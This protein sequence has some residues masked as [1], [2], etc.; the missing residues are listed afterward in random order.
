MKLFRGLILL[1]SFLFFSCFSYSQPTLLGVFNSSSSHPRM[2]QYTGGDTTLTVLDSFSFGHGY[3]ISSMVEGPDGKLYSLINGMDSADYGALISYDYVNNHLKVLAKFD[4]QHNGTDPLGKLLLSADGLLY[5]LTNNGGQ[6]AGGIIFSFDINTD[7][8]TR[9]ANF[10]NYDRPQG[11]LVQAQS[12]TFYTMTYGGGWSGGGSIVECGSQFAHT[13]FEDY[14]FPAGTHPTGTM[15][16]VGADSKYGIIPNGSYS[17]IFRYNV[18]SQSYNI[19]HVHPGIYGNLLHASNGLL[20]GSATS[21]STGYL[22]SYDLAA[23]RFDTLSAFPA[24]T[25]S[26]LYQASDSNIY[27]Y[28]STYPGR[29]GTIFQ[30]NINT[31]TYTPRLVL[32]DTTGYFMSDMPFVEYRSVAHRITTPLLSHTVCT[33]DSAVFFAVDSSTYSVSAQWH[34][35]MDSGRTYTIVPGCI[36]P[37]Y[38]F[39]VTTAMDGYM[40]RVKFSSGDTSTPATLHVASPVIYYQNISLCPGAYLIVGGNIHTTSGSYSDTL[41]GATIRGCDSIV[42]SS[43]YFYAPDTLS[44]DQ[45]ICP[46]SSYVINGHTYAAD[47]TYIDTLSGLGA[48]GCDSIVTTNLYVWLPDTFTQN[49][50]LCQGQALSLNGHTYTA[51]GTFIDIL[52]GAGMHGCDS[53]VTT[54]LIVWPAA[55]SSQHISFCHGDSVPVNG[56]MYTT[57]AS[58]IDTL[59]GMS[60]NGCDSMVNTQLSMLDSIHAYFSLQ[61]TATPHLWYIVNQCSA[62]SALTYSWSW[63][64]GS[65]NGTTD[66]ASHIYSTAGYYTVCV[67]VTDS[68]GCRASYCDSNLYLFKEQA[69][70]MIEVRVVHQ[71]PSLIAETSDQDLTLYPNPGSG[72]FHL[73]Y[74]PGGKVRIKVSDIL[75]SSLREY[76]ASGQNFTFD[77]SDFAPGVYLLQ[78]SGDGQGVSKT[79]RLVKD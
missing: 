74:G 25:H 31:G 28:R 67:A 13:I 42:L 73:V 44:Q 50:A 15:I 18:A 32:N 51:S 52:A 26:D 19:V 47:G 37:T 46:G 4:D 22:F 9:L 57:A 1:L 76:T 71:H 24:G 72:T 63:G 10:H 61:A 27:G 53:M 77:I 38:K 6:L 30:Y 20:Y 54:H 45:H 35:S 11:S 34:V 5:G 41:F 56:H 33:N 12:G 2:V 79:I 70:Q 43:L 40:Y 66:T 75:G 60:V 16:E 55:F 78:I 8:I 49:L 21:G 68:E 29:R 69:A 17:H 23:N 36:S 59:I 62:T 65:A 14:V 48:H 7:S 58:I 3:P 64:D 39:P